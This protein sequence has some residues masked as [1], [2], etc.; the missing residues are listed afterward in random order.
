[1]KHAK[2]IF[3]ITLSLLVASVMLPFTAANAAV[4]DNGTK[5]PG[6]SYY[7]NDLEM[8]STLEHESDSTS[9][10][11]ILPSGS[12]VPTQPS[13]SIHRVYISPSNQ[14][15]NTYTDVNTNEMEQCY[16][17][18]QALKTA[19][20][21]NGIQVMLAAKGQSNAKSIAESNAFGADLHIP[22]H[23]NA[24]GGEGTLVMVYSY[25]SANMEIAN[26]LYSD[27]KSITLS[28]KGY[29]V[30]TFS[31]FMGYPAQL[32]ELSETN[33]IGCY[34]EVD[35]HDN[36]T[37]A[38]WLVNNTSLVAET[39]C[40][41]IC[42]YFGETYHSVA[43]ASTFSCDINTDGKTNLKD[44]SYLQAYI[45]DEITLTSARKKL[46]DLNS[47]GKVNTADIMIFQKK[48]NN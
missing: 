29:G 18:G 6:M 35:F 48:L 43:A 37:I 5:V 45:N 4:S 2:K 36:A 21:R 8:P 38:K 20:E 3:A 23:T 9:G 34:V 12:Q 47:D 44:A 19:L 15:A 13:G 28:H 39:M 42:D 31:D 16:K 22:I 24:G 7:D 14:D 10:T 32:S 17:F 46:A 40:K 27:L 1:M 26:R 30:K 41:S 11:A 25:A 33:A